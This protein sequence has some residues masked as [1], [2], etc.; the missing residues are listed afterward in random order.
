MVLHY[1]SFAELKKMR[2]ITDS[3]SQFADAVRLLEGGPQVC[4]GVRL[5]IFDV[6]SRQ[7]A[8]VVVVD[9]VR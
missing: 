8:A 9:W 1:V 3:S 2:V 5:D 6:P 7:T 4:E